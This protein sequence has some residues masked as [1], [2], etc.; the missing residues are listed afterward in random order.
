MIVNQFSTHYIHYK[1]INV[2]AVNMKVK[3]YLKK[4]ALKN[5]LR[6]NRNK[7]RFILLLKIIS[8]EYMFISKF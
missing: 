7:N 5:Q 3:Y 4:N 8:K 6:C 1:T 2:N